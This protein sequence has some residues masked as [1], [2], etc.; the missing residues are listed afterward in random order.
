MQRKFRT[1]V[2][3]LSLSTAL[4]ACDQSDSE[5]EGSGELFLP[6]AGFVADATKGQQL[7]DKFCSRCHGA[8]GRGTDQGPPLVHIIYEPNHHGDM[9]FYMAA[10]KGV[11]HHHWNF[12][13]MPPVEGVTA[14]EVGH[15]IA[16]VRRQQRRAGIDTQ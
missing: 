9:A 4:V 6:P 16:Y 15:I 12:G 3:C 11:R 1:G 13:D 10:G 14:S 8:G 7:F 2:V 5:G